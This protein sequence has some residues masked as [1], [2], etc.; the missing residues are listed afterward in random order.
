MTLAVFKKGKKKDLGKYRLSQSDSLIS[1]P[2]KVI[3]QLFLNA[4]SK[5]LEEKVIKNSQHGFTKEKSCS[6]NLAA[7]SDDIT[8]PVDGGRAVDVI[9]LDNS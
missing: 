6:T 7:F 2:G 9:Y 4:I 8:S 3:E 1:V 5:L